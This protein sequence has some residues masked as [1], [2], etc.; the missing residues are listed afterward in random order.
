MK[1]NKTNRNP[2]KRKQQPSVSLKVKPSYIQV[3]VNAQI[4]RTET[5]LNKEN[6]KMRCNLLYNFLLK[7][8]P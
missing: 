8:L 2:I 3:R 4:E 7:Y 6:I 5:F 1:P